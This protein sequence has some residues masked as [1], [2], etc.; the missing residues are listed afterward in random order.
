MKALVM[1]GKN[2]DYRYEPNWAMPRRLKNWLLIKTKYSGV[3]GSDIP[4][5]AFNGSYSHPIIL[6]HEFSGV[7]EEADLDSSFHKNDPV[8]ILPI[9]PCEACDGC[10]SSG[11]FH[12]NRY[13]FI[14]SRNDGG[15]AEYCAVPEKNALKLSSHNILKAGAFAEPMAVGLH[16][17]RRSGFAPGKTAV[18]FGAGPIGL[19]IGLWLREF[20]GR[21]VVMSDVRE[22]NLR[23]AK[24]FDFETADLSTHNISILGGIDYAYEAAGSSKALCDAIEVLNGCGTLTIV[25]RDVNDTIIPLKSFETLMRKELQLISCW[26]YDMR[27]EYEFLTGAMERNAKLL[28]KLITHEVTIENAASMIN[29]MCGKIIEYCK[30]MITF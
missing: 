5:F 21:R 2:G 24:E 28:G 7:V 18:V 30:V 23:I 4:R 14:G 27:G 9:I 8:A 19:M 3:C 12:C 13:Q 25:G 26:G 17:V 15:F 1:H 11:P 20:G 6:G 22:M 10:M 16:A 29:A